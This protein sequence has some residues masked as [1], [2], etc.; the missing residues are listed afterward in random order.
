MNQHKILILREF[1]V[2]TH[3]HIYAVKRIHLYSFDF[4]NTHTYR[5]VTN[6]LFNAHINLYLCFTAMIFFFQKYNEIS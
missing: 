3:V 5:K 2:K 6:S 4:K 1:P